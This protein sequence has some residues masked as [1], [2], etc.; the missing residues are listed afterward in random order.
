MI[1]I[2]LLVNNPQ[3]VF[4]KSLTFSN[5]F[6]QNRTGDIIKKLESLSKDNMLFLDTFS[7]H[8]LNKG[9]LYRI[10]GIDN[11]YFM[12]NHFNNKICNFYITYVDTSKPW[13][14]LPNYKDTGMETVK[15]L[16]NVSGYRLIDADYN[17]YERKN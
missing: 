4:P 9:K 1:K 17:Y 6:P 16:S 8:Q 7:V 11:S 12:L 13:T 15:Y 5:R 14:I 3:K 2:M 10:Q